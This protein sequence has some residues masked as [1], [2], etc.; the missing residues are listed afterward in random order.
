MKKEWTEPN[1]RDFQI[2]E[3]ISINKM[4][5]DAWCEKG[6][7]APVVSAKFVQQ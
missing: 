1:I 2:D 6:K 7:Q 4:D 5:P 3:G